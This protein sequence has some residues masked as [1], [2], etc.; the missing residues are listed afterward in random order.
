MPALLLLRHGKSDWHAG[1]A[2]DRARPLA[3]RGRKAARAI[4]RFLSQVD[5]VPDIAIT[6]P[7]VRAAETLE[8]AMTAGGWSCPVR[9][10]ESLYDG[11]VTGLLEELRRKGATADLILVVGHEPT[12]SAT[13]AELIGGGHVR[14]PTGALARIN[15]DVDAWA[16]LGPGTGRL[17]WAVNPR[18]LNTERRS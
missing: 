4:G 15:L 8:L 6:S 13:A 7:A 9:V 1:A 11:G 12:W 3:P 10:A 5:Q 18:L 17:A 14:F 16:D 2:D